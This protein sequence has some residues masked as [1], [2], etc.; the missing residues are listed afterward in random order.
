MDTTTAI[1]PDADEIVKAQSK[2]LTWSVHL[3]RRQSHRLP[4]I[5]CVLVLV[6]LSSIWLFH[7]FWLAMLPT[8]AALFSVSEFVFPIHY[9][10][11]TKSAAMKCGL[12]A[13]EI[14]WSD[15]RHAY[16]TDEGIK[17]SPLRRKNSRMEPLRGVFLRFGEAHR[18]EIIAAVTRLRQE[19][20]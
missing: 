6:F 2:Q 3:L 11:T 9:T 14:Q 12:T 10:L 7:S 20:Q 5:I 1:S 18:E 16:L 17:L 19:A 15:V 4:K 8:L 13:L